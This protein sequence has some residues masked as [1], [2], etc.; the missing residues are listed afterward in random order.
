MTKLSFTYSTEKILAVVVAVA[1]FGFMHLYNSIQDLQ[2][3][4]NE[5]STELAVVEAV[6]ENEVDHRLPPRR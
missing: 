1:A 4:F 6:E 5:L 3:N 2:D